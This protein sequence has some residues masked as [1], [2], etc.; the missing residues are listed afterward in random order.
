M[1]MQIFYPGIPDD[2]SPATTEPAAQECPRCG[3]FKTKKADRSH[4]F[5]DDC[6]QVTW[7]FPT[8]EP[9][10]GEATPRPWQPWRPN[11]T[12]Y[13]I[14]NSLKIQPL[15][16]DELVTIRRGKRGSVK[17]SIKEVRDSLV[18][19]QNLQMVKQRPDGCYIEVP[20]VEAADANG[21]DWGKP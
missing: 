5:C 3:G 13:V 16:F 9:V 17:R 20:D 6:N 14:L 11:Y 4:L 1:T 15:A 12:D 2:E 7:T 10:G 21:Y 8:T 19:L 18:K